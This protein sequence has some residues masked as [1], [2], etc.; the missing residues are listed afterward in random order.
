MKQKRP[1]LLLLYPW[2]SSSTGGAWHAAAG[3]EERKYPCCSIAPVSSDRPGFKHSWLQICETWHIAW[4]LAACCTLK[5]RHSD[6]QPCFD[7]ADSK[8][9]AVRET[10]S[11]NDFALSRTS[12]WCH[13]CEQSALSVVFLR[14][15]VA[16]P[17]AREAGMH[18][19]PKD[20]SRPL[21]LRPADSPTVVCQAPWKKTF[22]WMND[23]LSL[24]ELSCG[25][26]LCS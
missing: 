14:P 3:F 19:H 7:H 6:L 20:E 16:L 13:H 23:G 9:L 21:C 26:H 1:S 18:P 8:G 15:R 5:P 22:P 17:A 11:M 12:W 4:K 24:K 10:H 25:H 2:K